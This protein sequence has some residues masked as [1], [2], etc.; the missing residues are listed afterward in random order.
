MTH[1]WS[2]T[3]LPDS[4]GQYYT[5]YIIHTVTQVTYNLQWGSPQMHLSGR[6]QVRT[7]KFLSIPLPM[8]SNDESTQS[9]AWMH[10]TNLQKLMANSPH[11]QDES[12]TSRARPK[13]SPDMSSGDVPET[14]W[15]VTETDYLLRSVAGFTKMHHRLYQKWCTTCPSDQLKLSND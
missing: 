14:D 11:E 7:L 1:L 4:P 6:P 10:Q 2:L 15:A 9:S 5:N 12:P 13:H 3:A 8:S